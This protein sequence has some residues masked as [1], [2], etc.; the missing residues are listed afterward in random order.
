LSK[1]LS[2]GSAPSW[3]PTPLPLPRVKRIKAFA[4][5][6][7]VRL[8]KEHKATIATFIC[9]TSPCRLGVVTSKLRIEGEACP[10]KMLLRKHD[11]PEARPRLRVVIKSR[12]LVTLKEAH[13]GSLLVNVR[14]GDALGRQLLRVRVTIVVGR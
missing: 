11:D 2:D 3:Q 4:K 5:K 10:V 8:E 7:E 6:G 9:G 14:F 1:I 12:C 13:R